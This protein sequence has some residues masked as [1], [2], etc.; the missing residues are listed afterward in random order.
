MKMQDLKKQVYEAWKDLSVFNSAVVQAENFKGM[1]PLACNR[2]LLWTW[3]R[4]QAAARPCRCS[5]DS[6]CYMKETVAVACSGFFDHF[7][8]V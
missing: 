2:R 5:I 7:D 8:D 1:G 4:K 6:K 3:E